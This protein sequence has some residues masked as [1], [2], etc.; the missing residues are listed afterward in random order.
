[1]EGEDLLPVVFEGPDADVHKLTDGE[2]LLMLFYL[3]YLPDGIP[4][5]RK[6]GVYEVYLICW[7]ED[8]RAF[9]ETAN[10]EPID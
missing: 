10:E 5:K 9:R 1:M 2:E 3:L 7:Y 8:D 4:M 6:P